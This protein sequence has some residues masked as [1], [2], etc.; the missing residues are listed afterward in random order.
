MRVLSGICA[1]PRQNEAMDLKDVYN[2]LTKAVKA[3]DL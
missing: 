3:A 2:Y 1:G